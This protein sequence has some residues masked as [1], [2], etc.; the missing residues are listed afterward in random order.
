MNQK[1]TR[2]RIIEAADRLFYQNG[3]EHTSFSDISGA[4]EISRGN[5]TFHFQTKDEILEAVIDLRLDRTR[6]LLEQWE[7][8]GERCEDR[9]KSFINTNLDTGPVIGNADHIVAHEFTNGSGSAYNVQ[10][11]AGD[12][13]WTKTNANASCPGAGHMQGSLMFL[14][15]HR[16]LRQ[17]TAPPS[18]TMPV[19]RRRVLAT[20]LEAFAA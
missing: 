4:V 10:L 8:D 11:P 15:L 7:A 1:A 6:R 14:R 12:I 17:C 20:R 5:V 9:I 18:A 3:Y 2:N 13:D 19:Q 16:S